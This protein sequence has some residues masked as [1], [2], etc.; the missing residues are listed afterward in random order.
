MQSALT[1]ELFGLMEKALNNREQIILFQNRRGYSPY[2]QCGSCGHIPKC[3]YCDVSLTFHKF[4]KQLVCHY[5]GYFLPNPSECPD[6]GSPDINTRGFGTEKIEDELKPLFPGKRIERMDMDTTRSKHAFEKII[7]NLES[8][9]TDILIGTQMVTKGLDFDHV[10]VVGILDADSLINF[11]NFR[12][13]ERAYQLISQ[14]SGRAGRKH[15]RGKVVVQTMQ[16]EHPVIGFI[17]KQ[18]YAAAFYAQMEERKLFRYPPFFR[19]IKVVVKHKNPDNVNRVAGQLAALLRNA[20]ELIVLGPEFPLVSRI[21]LW[22]HKEIWI[23]INPAYSLPKVKRYILENIEN[24]RRRPENSSCI[25]N[26]DV[27]PA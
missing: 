14:V 17:T 20:R 5:C 19:L 9:K 22:Y 15:S 4:R 18:D 3:K 23:K 24:V 25:I 16:P 2:V 26:I 1:P 12:A 21:Q 13:H 11:P 7:H 10:S 8:R 6:C 27:D